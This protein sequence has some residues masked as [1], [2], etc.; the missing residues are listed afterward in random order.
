MTDTPIAPI[1]NPLHSDDQQQHN[2]VLV[3]DPNPD[4][5]YRECLD[6]RL[7][8]EDCVCDDDEW[9]D[10]YCSDCDCPVDECICDDDD[11]LTEFFNGSGFDDSDDICDDCGNFVD[12]CECDDPL[13]DRE[14]DQVWP[15]TC[16]NDDCKRGILCDNPGCDCICHDATIPDALPF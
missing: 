14:P 7:P 16:N 10:V 1:F 15:S 11:G 4:P 2:P 6:C 13:V 12:E 9:I 5:D 3:D 8:V